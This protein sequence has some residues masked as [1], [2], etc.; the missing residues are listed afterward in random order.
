MRLGGDAIEYHWGTEL[1]DLQLDQRVAIFRRPLGDHAHCIG[2]GDGSGNGAQHTPQIS[3]CTDT[4]QT[5]VTVSVNYDLLLGADGIHSKVR[6]VME[7]QISG[8]SCK[9]EVPSRRYK[10]FVG[11]SNAKTFRLPGDDG[12]GGSLVHFFYLPQDTMPGPGPGALII[13]RGW[14]HTCILLSA[15]WYLSMLDG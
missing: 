15:L 4:A 13:R 8:F 5:G 12:S 2:A 3:A 6:T 14:L 1:V 10:R 11:V 9:I 7:M